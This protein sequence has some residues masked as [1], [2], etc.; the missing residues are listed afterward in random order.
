MSGG[1]QRALAG[2][3]AI[4]LIASGASARDWFF[5]PDN[6]AGYGSRD[7]SSY[8]DAWHLDDRQT[9][10]GHVDWS[11]MRPGDTLYVCGF[12]HTGRDRTLRPTVSGRR[13]AP[14]AIDG[15]CPT[16]Y[17]TD[18]G[19]MLLGGSQISSGWTGP[20]GHGVWALP[21]RGSTGSQLIEDSDDIANGAAGLRRLTRR[22]GEPDGSWTCGS[23]ANAG[24]GALVY[25]KPSDADGDGR[26]DA[27][28]PVYPVATRSVSFQGQ[29]DFVL[30]NLVLM[31]QD[32]LV[33]VSGAQRITIEQ[34]EL[35]WATETAIRAALNSDDGVIRNNRIHD[36]AGGIYFINQVDYDNINNMDG[37]LIAGNE[38]HDVDQD[39]Y[40]AC[41]GGGFADTHGI[42]T[43][44]ATGNVIERNHVHHVGGEGII[45]YA[46][47]GQTLRDNL[48]QYNLVH[49][50]V[51][52]NPYVAIRGKR[53]ER[54][55]EHGTSNEEVPDQTIN[56]VVRY[57]VLVNIGGAALKLKSSRPAS[58]YSWSVL[59]NVVYNSGTSFVWYESDNH[60]DT[61]PGFQLRNN[62]FVNPREMHLDQR[63]PDGDDSGI[64]ISNNLF[65]PDD[66][67]G[68]YR[69]SWNGVRYDSHATWSEA[70]GKGQDSLTVEPRF[71]NPV[72][73]PFRFGPGGPPLVPG[74]GDFRLAADS[75]AIDR[76]APVGAS[77]DLTGNAIAGSPDLGA[78]EHQPDTLTTDG[79]PAEDS[80][81]SPAPV[82]PDPA[83]ETGSSDGHGL[84][85]DLLPA[86]ATN[87]DAVA[88]PDEIFSIAS[89]G[90]SGFGALSLGV[91]GAAAW[92]RRRRLARPI[93]AIRQP[94]RD[95]FRQ[96]PALL[97]SAADDAAH[98][99]E[100]SRLAGLRQRPR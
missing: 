47:K 81:D 14:I 69:Y 49:D 35:S 2:L 27:P 56:N 25:Y 45:L 79:D 11:V 44:G 12:H 39:C 64:V 18:P 85:H 22:T 31:H 33:D 28:H 37:W 77:R 100:T 43:Q 19:I 1:G 30:R 41:Q 68:V 5:R 66:S 63:T 80:G 51:D 78:Y 73:G 94:G 24:D 46:M 20:D 29:S 71:R 60:P 87:H 89:S 95:I 84:D 38:I 8:A 34:N 76:G 61:H 83:A 92:Y 72:A 99:V 88:E 57:N 59:N 65:W 32:R 82:D 9:E 53:N 23:F 91:L 54:G 21:Y 97:E 6:G 98:A 96:R 93:W 7:G 52:L 16:A 17:G 90:G 40:Y 50:V 15:D 62:I 70:S 13:S 42:A 74:A 10:A 67:P 58:G 55:I 4:M 26:C 86:P 48:I 75:P 36:V 3:A